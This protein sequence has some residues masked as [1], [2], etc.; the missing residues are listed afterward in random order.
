MGSPPCLLTRLCCLSFPLPPWQVSE[1]RSRLSHK[2]PGAPGRE[3]NGDG[4][5]APADKQRPAQAVGAAV[6]A[7]A[8]AA[9]ASQDAGKAAPEQA[10]SGLSAAKKPSRKG[11]RPE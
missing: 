2:A 11:M 8:G 6:A 10:K 7:G 4:R 3:G 5:A 9:G 1:L